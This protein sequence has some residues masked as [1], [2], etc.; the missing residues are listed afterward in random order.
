[1]LLKHPSQLKMPRWI[2]ADAGGVI[3]HLRVAPSTRRRLG[4]IAPQCVSCIHA[5]RAAVMYILHN[6]YL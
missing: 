2:A 4:R 6:L 5:H 1:M 3:A